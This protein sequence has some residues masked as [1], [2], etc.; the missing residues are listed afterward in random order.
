MLADQKAGVENHSQVDRSD[1]RFFGVF[2]GGMDPNRAQGLIEII[3][4]DEFSAAPA[5]SWAILGGQL[6]FLLQ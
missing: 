2:L 5:A 3:E 4:Q 6:G 1:A